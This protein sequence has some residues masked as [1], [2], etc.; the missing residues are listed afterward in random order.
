MEYAQLGNTGVKIS[1]IILGTMQFGWR[2]DESTSHQI[3]DR[4]YELGI[5]CLDTADVYSRW[6]ENSYSGKSEEI[7]GRWLTKSQ[8]REDFV[9][10]TKV[11]HPLSDNVNDQGLNRRHINLAVKNSLKR[12]Q[13]DWIDLYQI[14]AFDNQ[15]L[16]QET[17]HSLNSL[18]D[19]G[20]VNYIG[21]SNMPSWRFVEALLTSE[22]HGYASFQSFQPPY[23]IARRIMVEMDFIE[24][25]SQ[26][27]TSI[28][29]YSPLGGGFLTGKY[30]SSGEL[31]DTPRSSS[32]QNKYSTT[33]R[34]KILESI[35]MIAKEHDYTIPQIALAWILERQFIT[36]PIIGA[37]SV[38][39]LEENLGA[40]DVKLT[41]D[42]LEHLDRVSDWKEDY[43]HIR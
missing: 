37:N 12:L 22:L 11:R 20:V 36:A 6:A 27:N 21:A 26:Y 40:L 42:N 5:N 38:E 19:Q 15:T 35:G 32:I 30:I 13:T 43:E 28:I 29:P 14:H 33:K 9:L 23:N 1:K 8:N 7:I 17:L 10:A 39:Q 25:V 16:I 34:W 3:L 41:A 4:A 18:I 31:P 24:I 2:I